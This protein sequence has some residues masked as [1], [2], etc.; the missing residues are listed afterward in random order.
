[1]DDAGGN[2]PQRE[3]LVGELHRVAGVM[4]ALVARHHVECFAE[5]VDDLPFALV[6]PLRPDDR[7]VLSLI[8]HGRREH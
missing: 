2:Q 6:S 3:V 1:M 7:N 4:A 8:S 5:Q